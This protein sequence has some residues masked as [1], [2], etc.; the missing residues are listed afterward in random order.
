MK[1]DNISPTSTVAP[2]QV[3]L[4][5]PF[6]DEGI[7]SFILEEEIDYATRLSHASRVSGSLNLGSI[8]VW[9]QALI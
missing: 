4:L 7:Y 9:I 3:A 2:D 1:A 5:S 6:Q 8:S